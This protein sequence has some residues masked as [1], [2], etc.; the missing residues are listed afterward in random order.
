MADTLGSVGVIIS[1]LLIEYYG[2]TGFDPIASLF[3]AFLI[4]GSVIPLVVDSGKILCLDMGDEK[5]DM[6]KGALEEVSL[7]SRLFDTVLNRF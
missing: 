3:I 7:A 1:T 2:W 6:V 4:V 5:E